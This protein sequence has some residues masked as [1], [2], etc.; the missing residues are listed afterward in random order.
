MVTGF[1]LARRALLAQRE[2]QKP[3][4]LGLHLLGQPLPGGVIFGDAHG[5]EQKARLLG[6]GR[7]D[8]QHGGGENDQSH[9][10]SFRRRGR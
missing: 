3:V 8:S 6:P 7:A 9:E 4:R 1:N 2:A 5:F 10:I